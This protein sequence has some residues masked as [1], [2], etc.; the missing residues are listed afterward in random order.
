MS[1][2]N[3]KNV[4]CGK[5]QIQEYLENISLKVEVG[6]TVLRGDELS[7][8][9]LLLEIM[10]AM[11]KVESGDVEIADTDITDFDEDQLAVYRR[12]YVGMLLAENCFLPS[13]N[14]Y[15]N[16]ILPLELDDSEV[17][18][19]YIEQLADMVGIKTKLFDRYE[20]LTDSEM[21]R[22][23]FIRAL[24]AKPRVVVASNIEKYLSEKELKTMLGI[25]RMTASKY[26]QSIVIYSND[27][28]LKSLADHGIEMQKGEIKE[29][30]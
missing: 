9:A 8:A 19:E 20:T 24:S 10:G 22:A 3:L 11:K 14:I 30:W 12:R 13:I 28:Q 7:G 1:V 26:Q 27:L 17:D 15:E 21:V 5:G 4:C 6:I 23:A 2:I 25:W 18:V 29:I 16:I